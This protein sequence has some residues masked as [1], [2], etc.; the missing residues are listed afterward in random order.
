MSTPRNDRDGDGIADRDEQ[1]DPIV[2]DGTG[3]ATVQ[4]DHDGVRT[5]AT[6]TPAAGAVPAPG[7][8]EREVVVET[9]D[10]HEVVD[11]ERA[12][13]GGIK[14][15]SA[16]FGW[17]T[18]MGMA[19]L[20]TSIVA[21]AGLAVGLSTEGEEN[22]VGPITIT[23][24]IVL[25]VILFV[26]YFCGGYVAGRMARFDGAKQGLAVWLWAIIAAVVAAVLGF[27]FGTQ[28]DVLANLDAFPRIPIRPE[29]A[30]VAGIVTALVL[31]IVSLLAA[32]LGGLAGMRYHRRVDRTG[33]GV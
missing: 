22:E 11:R 28:F 15:G 5:P 1:H 32:I 8:V 7:V 24:A 23:A 29:D 25:V 20:I 26:A 12:E 2:V 3:E 18:A 30:T 9:P 16:F 27:L 14:F 13:H 33:L 6:G 10:R 19:V 17:L 31:A 21:A 4:H